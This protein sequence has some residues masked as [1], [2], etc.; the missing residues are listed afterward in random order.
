MV[1]IVSSCSRLDAVVIYFF[2]STSLRCATL[3]SYQ[4][5]QICPI[6]GNRLGLFIVVC[7]FFTVRALTSFS[8]HVKKKKK[9]VLSVKM[10]IELLLMLFFN[11]CLSQSGDFSDITNWPTPGE[12]AKEVRRAFDVRMNKVLLRSL[13]SLEAFLVFAH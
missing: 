2:R 12:L 5:V 10:M 11:V 7:S 3:I 13:N 9:R 4:F 1:F 8:G 6:D